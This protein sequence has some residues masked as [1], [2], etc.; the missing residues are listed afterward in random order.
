M[1]QFASLIACQMPLK[2]GLPWIRGMLSVSACPCGRITAIATRAARIAAVTAGF[3]TLERFFICSLSHMRVLLSQHRCQVSN[4]GLELV[5][6][7][8]NS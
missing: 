1:S 4:S 6:R 7:L 3:E 8:R 2:L 5:P